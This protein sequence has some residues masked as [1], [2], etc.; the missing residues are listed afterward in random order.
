MAV[1]READGPVHASRLDAAWPQDGEQ[2][3][4]CLEGLVADGLVRLTGPS[5]W[6]LPELAFPGTDSAPN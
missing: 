5:S 1:L 3:S 4:R 2:R 6:A